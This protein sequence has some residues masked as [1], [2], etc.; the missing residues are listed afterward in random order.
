MSGLLEKN[1][2]A[3]HEELNELKEALAKYDETE[4]KPCHVQG[5]MY[6]AGDRQVLIAEYEGTVYQ[7]D[8]L[9]SQSNLAHLWEKLLPEKQGYMAKYI[10]FGLG[11]GMLVRKVLERSDDSVRIYVYEPSMVF[12]HFLLSELDFSDILADQR[13]VVMAEQE[14]L[15]VREYLTN[16]VDYR[17]LN[18]LYYQPFFNYRILFKKEQREFLDEI[19][20]MY[21]SV[22]ATQNVLGRYGEKYYTNL[23][24]NCSEFIKSKSLVDL[25]AK[26]PK[27]IPF[28]I[29]SSGPSLD[30]NIEYLKGLKGRAFMIAADSALRVLLRHD[31]Y[32]DMFVSVDGWK[33]PK[34]FQD[35][36]IAQIPILTEASANRCTIARAKGDRYFFND[37]NPHINAFFAEKGIVLPRFATGGSVA[38]TAYSMA[39]GM[40]F[41][42][43][44]LVGQDLAYTD[45]K[46]HSTESVRGEDRVDV[47]KLDGYMTE[48]YYGEMVKTSYEFQLYKS[49]FEEEIEKHPEIRTINA[50][51]G[52]ALI[53]GAENMPLKDAVEQL[54]K[55]EYDID[56][57]MADIEDML[58]DEQKKELIVFLQKAPEE[59]EWIKAKVQQ[60]V[61]DYDKLLQMAYRGNLK[62]SEMKRL[63]NKMAEVNDIVEKAPVMYYIQN[64][65]QGITNRY[66]EQVYEAKDGV[67]TEIIDMS[68]AGRDYLKEVLDNLETS[69]VHI[70]Y[71]MTALDKE[72]FEVRDKYD[73]MYE[74]PME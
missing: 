36:R 66:L 39:V 24:W 28:I 25:Y 55:E 44:I 73:G 27:Q 46:T 20:L 47:K 64:R 23:M 69:L 12:C 15:N 5:G 19:Q 49:W 71:H 3:M 60:G 1:I 38:N 8:S 33:N 18:Q 42:T 14:L 67:R 2:A 61:R 22:S 51:E 54:C 32:P 56:G 31:I 4:Y 26:M 48:G 10:F 63:L 16:Y 17:D 62:Q 59:L 50:T 37:L 9:Y 13:V 58:L 52:G 40:E 35:P 41:K 68:R 21:N 72:V 65:M 70:T 11:N 29:V 57:I 34:H 74:L 45:N 6:Q 7:L 30:K 53:K 43:V